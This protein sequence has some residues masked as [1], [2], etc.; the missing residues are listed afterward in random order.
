M[1]YRQ[2]GANGPQIPVIMFGAWPIGGGMGHVDEATAIA[3]I[4]RALELGITAIDTAEYYRGSEALIG[5][6]LAGWPREKVFIATKVSY[7]PYTRTLIR[8][9]LDNSLRALRTD[10]VDLYQ[11]H[12]Y[13]QDIAL[14]E[15]IA[16]LAE[17]HESGK[18]RYVGVSNFTRDQL[19]AAR[20]LYPIQAVQNRF[21]IFDSEAARDVLPFCQLEGIGFLAHSP[22]AKGLLTGKY[23]P[24][25]VFPPDDE[26][27][28][29]PWFQGETFARSVAV[30]D[31]LARLAREK[32]IT[33]TQL[34]IAWVLAHPG[35]TSCIVGA[36]TPAQVEEH[37][38]AIGVRLTS[39]DL[40]RI[41][42]LAARVTALSR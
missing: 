29:H 36:K 2:L 19:A 31:E 17:A 42:A 16:G 32:G 10:Y 3:T 8:Q 25:H 37:V 22:L 33:L 11:L 20:A 5:R 40:N 12:S 27:S 39:D 4:R 15:A 1:E 34:A 30:V 13:P 14:E 18:A 41:A 23:R 38:G 6:A 9:A 26:R 21:N 24:G 35:V 28:R 7:G